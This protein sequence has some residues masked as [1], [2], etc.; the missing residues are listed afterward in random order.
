MARSSG[1]A[2]VPA[3]AKSRVVMGAALLGLAA[4][5]LLSYRRSARLEQRLAWE[6]AQW[7]DERAELEALGR[8]R[9]HAPASAGAA[10]TT[11]SPPEILAR[12][13]RLPASGAPANLQLAVYWLEELGRHGQ[14]ALPAIAARLETGQDV[15]LDV[16][17]Y[18]RGKGWRDRLPGD[19]VAPP[20]LRFGLF[21]VVRQIG[22]PAGEALLA[23]TL[24]TRR[25]VELAYLV[26]VLEELSPQVHRAQ[27][28]AAARQL[29]DQR[30]SPPF[31]SPLD[32]YHREHL[33]S[34]LAFYGDASYVARAQ[35]QL[36]TPE[37]IDRAS[38][39]YLRQALGPRSVGVVAQA[40]NEQRIS[41]PARREPLDRLAL[42]YVPGDPQATALWKKA[43]EDPATPKHQR[44]DL[45]EDLNDHGFPDPK[46]L[47]QRDLPL[48]E[49]R[50]ALIEQLAPATTDPVNAAAFQEAYK[51]LQN[52]KRY[53]EGEGP[54]PR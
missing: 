5:A 43:I 47:T 39:E 40:F 51:D 13:Q 25:G 6:R 4:L 1:A 28:L 36:F 15:D 32:R 14:A 9:S 31:T 7:S 44:Q 27:A 52:M 42:R 24:A 11:L 17:W 2:I 37:G 23:A 53:L 45:I 54:P 29:L 10:P 33:L 30:G 35:T 18:E 19:F 20:S 38:L 12:L 22:G 8:D 46:H 41:D 48:V 50:L 26:R 16:G 21:G 49:S 3:M 34:V